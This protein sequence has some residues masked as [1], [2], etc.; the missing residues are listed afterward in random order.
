VMSDEWGAG[1][2]SGEW[3]VGSGCVPICQL[4]AIPLPRV[5]GA[6]A[7]NIPTPMPKLLITHH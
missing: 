1:V 4:F 6:L 3:G 7:V 5:L 2:G